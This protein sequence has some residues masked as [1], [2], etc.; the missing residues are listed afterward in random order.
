[1]LHQI[2]VGVVDRPENEIVAERANLGLVLNSDPYFVSKGDIAIS[3]VVWFLKDGAKFLGWDKQID[4]HP[5]LVVNTLEDVSKVIEMTRVLGLSQ[6][7]EMD[8]RKY[9]SGKLKEKGVDMETRSW[10]DVRLSRSAVGLTED[11]SNI[12]STRSNKK[13]SSIEMA[14]FVDKV[15]VKTSPDLFW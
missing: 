3:D 2:G 9:V 1:M 12:D 6:L 11:S 13:I 7:D 14:V 15:L 8:V 4:S 5:G 10:E